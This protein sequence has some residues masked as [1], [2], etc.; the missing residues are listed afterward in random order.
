MTGPGGPRRR[1]PLST[2]PTRRARRPTDGCTPVKRRITMSLS[3]VAR[4]GGRRYPVTSRPILPVTTHPPRVRLPS[5]G[6]AWSAVQG[7]RS[8]HRPRLTAGRRLSDPPVETTHERDERRRIRGAGRRAES[9]SG[10]GGYVLCPRRVSSP[11]VLPAG[12]RN[13]PLTLGRW[14]STIVIQCHS[15]RTSLPGR[16]SMTGIETRRTWESD[17]PETDR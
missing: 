12:G 17:G 11:R 15:I 14:R 6:Q 16:R 5:D 7:G 9:G 4:A 10:D 1:Y 3:R 2:S 8:P 13:L